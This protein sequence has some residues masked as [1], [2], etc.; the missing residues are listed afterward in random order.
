M[1]LESVRELKIEANQLIEKIIKESVIPQSFSKK[2][3]S[4]NWTGL[5]IHPTGK[6]DDYKLAIHVND[7]SDL[8]LI[9][10]KVEYLA[11]GEVDIRIT[12]N[13]YPQNSVRPYYKRPLSIGLSISRTH[14]TSAGTLGCFVQKRGQA[15]LL[16]LSCNHV[17]ANTNNAHIGDSIIQP[18]VEDG[19]NPET[20][21]IANLYEFIQLRAGQPN[22]ADAA[23][24]KVNNINEIE[25]LCP[26]HESNLLQL[27]CRGE[28]LEE[29]RHLVVAKVGRSSNLTVG[30]INAVEMEQ[31]VLYE[32][33]GSY[34]KVTF[35]NLTAIEGLN[36][37]PFSEL[38]DSGSIIVNIKGEPIGLLVGGARKNQLISYANPIELV[39]QELNIELAHR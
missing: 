22:F 24:A 13:V 21:C 23:I 18:A 28:Y 4:W 38:G 14:P 26:F 36:N 25:R 11:K 3:D 7:K 32:N 19:G 35:P 27:F 34:M 17:L 30:R 2:H 16:I 5:G 9:K 39:C 37:E 31:Q 8:A 1:H 29:T 6:R 12:G 10:E 15:D 20:E 33:N